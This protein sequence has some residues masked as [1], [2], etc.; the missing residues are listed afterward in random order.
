MKYYIKTF[1]FYYYAPYNLFLKLN[2]FYFR[3]SYRLSLFSISPI[4]FCISS[5]IPLPKFQTAYQ[6][7]YE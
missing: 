7:I 5:N 4:Q 3:H 1:L 2:M 6:S